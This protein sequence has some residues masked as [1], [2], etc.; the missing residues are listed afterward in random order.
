M[1]PDTGEM[2]SLEEFKDAFE[3]KKEGFTQIFEVGELIQIK[4]CYFVVNNFVKEANFMNLKFI[5]KRE[6]ADKLFK[7]CKKF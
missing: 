7:E 2:R 6:A 5:S 3:A 1:N 4:G